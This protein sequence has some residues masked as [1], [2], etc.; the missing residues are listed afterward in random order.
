[1][2]THHDVTRDNSVRSGLESIK[3][4]GNE[5]DGR[6]VE[7]WRCAGGNV[8]GHFLESQD[9]S[10]TAEPLGRPGGEPKLQGSTTY[11]ATEEYPKELVGVTEGHDGEPQF[12]HPHRGKPQ[13][14]GSETYQGGTV[15]RENMAGQ[16]GETHYRGAPG[17]VPVE[18]GTDPHLPGIRRYREGEEGV[19]THVAGQYGESQ[20]MPPRYVLKPGEEPPQLTDLQV[21]STAETDSSEM[22]IHGVT[23]DQESSSQI[24]LH[25][26]PGQ[27]DVTNLTLGQIPVPQHDAV[28]VNTS[29]GAFEQPKP[30][31]DADK[32]TEE[33]PD[34]IGAQLRSKGQPDTHPVAQDKEAIRTEKV[35]VGIIPGQLDDVNLD[36]VRSNGDP[37][38]PTLSE[39][40]KLT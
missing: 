25:E 31:P 37:Q 39:V 30:Q 16:Y 4:Y 8:A 5:V 22:P 26:L 27:Q 17:V 15:V 40:R 36:S 18:L 21:C 28:Q 38:R 7:T 33:T 13:Q 29:L 1:M 24:Q 9:D 6:A 23:S 11:K 12:S 35:M 10:N 2:E 19:I 32:K 3:P 20:S 34:V 14:P